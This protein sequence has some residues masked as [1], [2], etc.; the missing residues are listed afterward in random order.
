[1]VAVP[2]QTSTDSRSRTPSIH[3]QAPLPSNM[4]KTV[5][6]IPQRDIKT[7]SQTQLRPGKPTGFSRSSQPLVH[8]GDAKPLKKEGKLIPNLS[9]VNQG[10]TSQPSAL[11]VSHENENFCEGKL[12]FFPSKIQSS[13]K[14]DVGKAPFNQLDA[15]SQAN[16]PAIYPWSCVTQDA[17]KQQTIKVNGDSSKL[18]DSMKQIERGEYCILAPGNDG[19]EVEPAGGS[20]EKKTDKSSALQ[21]Q[22]QKMAKE[23]CPKIE[24]NPK[25]VGRFV[26]YEPKYYSFARHIKNCISSELL[27]EWWETIL[28]HCQWLNPSISERN[29]PRLVCWLTNEGCCCTYSYSGAASPP[30]TK[31]M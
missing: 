3:S 29:I 6:N 25:A 17:P 31:P 5:N 22:L 18:M 7:F 23:L 26:L 15:P 13:E 11:S 8:T 12:G 21:Q 20:S 4:P 2:P 24:G 1:M 27:S 28:L 30:V 14:Q 16:T 10:F 9:G 19:S